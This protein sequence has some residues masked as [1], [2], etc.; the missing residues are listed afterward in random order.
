MKD[1]IRKDLENNLE[2]GVVYAL[3]RMNY[4]YIH[5]EEFIVAGY[6][7]DIID[8]ILTHDMLQITEYDIS[9]VVKVHGIEPSLYRIGDIRTLCESRRIF[10][11]E[12][13]EFT[14]VFGCSHYCIIS[15][16]KES[17]LNEK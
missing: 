4:D 11:D 10:E 7:N 16:K 3:I 1:A 5:N 13:D 15:N 9:D 12:Y 8:S 2:E 6:K 14:N 17:K